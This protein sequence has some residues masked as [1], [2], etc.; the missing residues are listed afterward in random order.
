MSKRLQIRRGSG[1]PGNIFYEG[2]PIFDKVNK[3][4]YFGDSGSS[5]TGAGTSLA[6][7]ESYSAILEFL[8]SASATSS[9]SVRFY[10]DTDNG[11]NYVELKAPSSVGV[12]TVFILPVSDGT[13]NQI[14]KTDGQGQLGFVTV[15][16]SV[17]TDLQNYLTDIVN[18]T[19]PQLGG[20]LDLNG[21]NITGTGNLNVTGIVTA[22]SFVKSSGTSTEFLKAD[23]SVDNNTYLTS[24]GDASNLTNLTGAS[25]ATYGDANFT[26][27]IVVDANGRIT[28]I[29]TVATSGSGGGGGGGGG[30]STDTQ[31]FDGLDSTSFLRSD[32]FDIKTSGYLRLDSGVKLELGTGGAK[33]ELYYTGT[34]VLLY[35]STPDIRIGSKSGDIIFGYNSGAATTIARFNNAGSVELNYATS[36]KF[37]TTSTG[38]DVTGHTETDTLN[39]S[40]VS[41]F[42]GDVSF[43]STATFGDDDKL[44]F[45][46][47]G[48]LQIYHDGSDSY[49]LDD[50][51]GILSIDT[52]YTRFRNVL[53]NKNVATFTHSTGVA[54][55]VTLYWDG[56]PK[57]Q[58]TGSGVTVYGTT[59]TQQLN[60]SGVSTFT[61]DVLFG[62]TATF[63]DN[64]KL[65][66]G[67]SVELEIYSNG[68]SSFI[69]E[70]GS[71]NL[72][73][74]GNSIL[75]KDTA[76]SEFYAKFNQNSSVELYHDNSKKFE[77]TGIGVSI[78][79]TGNTATITGPSNLVLDPG[80]VGDNTGTV[81]VHGNLQVDGTQTVINSTTM[82]VDDLNI[83]LAS[84]AENA[85]AAN[86][87]GLTVDGASAT[88]NYASS[89]DKWVANK[90]IEATSF[91]KNGG[92]SS[93]FLKADGSVDTSTYLTSYT[94]TDP[95]VAAIN[96]IVKSNG[97]TIAAAVAGTD[98]LAPSGDGS[99]LTNVNATTLDSIDSGSFLRSDAADTKT[100]GNLNFNDSIQARF[101][102][103]GD[104]TLV[105]D[106]TDNHITSSFDK[107]LNIEVSPDGGTPKI[108]IRPTTSHQGITLGGGSGNP[109]ELYHN[110]AKKFETIGTGV[111]VTGDLIVSNNA[112]ITG[113]LTVGSSSITLDGSDNSIH[114]FDTLIA[115]PKRADT[116]NISV[117]VGSKTTANRY[118]D[119]GAGNSYFLNG[120][121]A[122]FLTLTPGRTYRFT[123][124]SSDMTNHPFRLYL[125]ADKTTAYTTNVTSTA[126]YTEIVV[127]DAT[128]SVL[129]YQCSAHSLM[130]NSVQTNSSVP[131][132][133][134][135]NL[136]GVLSDVVE[137]T[138][139][140]LGGNLDLNSN[141]INGT[142]NIDVTGTISATF[143][144]AGNAA[145]PIIELYRNSESP[146][147]NDNT[148]QINFYG[149][150]DADE[151]V[152]YSYIRSKITDPTDGSEDG[153]LDFVVMN[154]GS[155]STRMVMQ[156]GGKT[157]FSN[158]DILLGT[159]VDLVFEG[160]TD[161]DYETTLTVVDPTQDNT[162]TFPDATG[163]VLL[164][165]GSASSLTGLTG[166]SAA[167]YG[168][169]TT[170]PVITVDAN[171]RI[172]T[173]STASISGGGGGSSLWTSTGYT[174]IGTASAVGIGTIIEIIPYD[175]QNSGTLSF[176][177]SAGQLF[178]ITNNLSS[179]SIFSVN[180]IS[181]I[182]SIDVDADGTILFAPYS[183]T[184][185]VGIGTTNPQ[186][187]LHVIGD[188]EITGTLTN[189]GSSVGGGGVSD[190]DKG[191]I[192][193]SNSGATWTID[194][195]VVTY[196]KM[197]D[198]VTANRVLGGTAAGTISEVQVQTAMV[199]DDAVTYA[200]IQNVSA[201]DR[202]LGRDSAG[203]GVIE[204][205][206]PANVRTMLNVA[207]GATAYSNSDVDS[208][209][210]QSNPTSGHVLS[211]NGSDY[212]WVAQS[213][214]GSGSTTRS[215]N[216]YVA[217]NNQTL[218]PPSGTVSYTVGYI[219][220]YL[221]GSK[222]YSTEFTASN[223]TTVTLTTGASTND[224]VELVAYTNVSIT[225][226][227][228][229]DDTSPQ[230]G[231][232]LDL[233]G[234]DITGTGNINVT[235]TA[236]VTGG[237]VATQND[238]IAFAIALG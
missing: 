127:N 42:T 59:E 64:D 104:L 10:E 27:V 82:T 179:G 116:V 234:N 213:G 47:D 172:T 156:G 14:L 193:V 53:G 198:L 125:E 220:V 161:N 37:E 212:A 197:Q 180:D 29:T 75:I 46:D 79:G 61:G 166:A 95:V 92:A 222:L 118:Y 130:G 149:E 202:L 208:H 235:G 72:K 169:S 62:S 134:G 90:S 13:P 186:Y 228:V 174:G 110:N 49:I 221:N 154:A 182:P 106:G 214:G 117:T 65:K 107:D 138:T 83:T 35:T 103:S 44:K 17:V 78:V 69:K 87:A 86:G 32:V 23:G 176:E 108:Y 105:H 168:N 34:D 188:V 2:E 164:T 190:G 233:N 55:G 67:D 66:F 211:W 40:G 109:V 140:E 170:T 200:K 124:S 165:D 194:S 57:F 28:G 173:I 215:V 24:S 91:I 205:I 177:A 89:G 6:S 201:T 16:E 131:V 63:G 153:R 3:V 20:D 187:K 148:G 160:A 237:Q 146:A 88:F 226:V 7:A 135:A 229:V 155:A 60:V 147:V 231:G 115:P 216:R 181:G 227:T 25:A 36:K 4:L 219:D 120:V 31:L 45:G 96:G 217:T 218:F 85:A 41:T 99:S 183:T 133:S 50:G 223:G 224:I 209:L 21:N 18:D 30:I 199:A 56:D 158:Q 73:V 39:V 141:D 26:P 70:S 192:T 189:N 206:T 230:L 137:D 143:T 58:T 159:N 33:G 5:G 114:G 119:Q 126:T 236:T 142:G 71:G 203:A 74:L 48:D 9:G 68:S 80:T 54:G 204:E 163:T 128:P 77:T 102:N 112:R 11:I 129:H 144:G 84:G 94:E 38:I 238:A 93:E 132:G 101:G 15:T 51:T 19:T 121:E 1:N 196:D 175:T 122:P 210:N 152:L 167:T 191:D 100:S 97:T 123:L 139:P 162:I 178:S 111:T 195:D 52:S 12:N 43:G 151:K 76:D 145:G 171:G 81:T 207:D 232:D 184:E 136:T 157:L 98:Y 113:I 185:K 22:T 150:N 225:N 8:S